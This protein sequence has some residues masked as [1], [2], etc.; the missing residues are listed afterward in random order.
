MKKIGMFLLLTAFSASS[1]A[2]DGFIHKRAR[3]KGGK[4][5][6]HILTTQK[7]WRDYEYGQG[8]DGHRCFGTLRKDRKGNL[9]AVIAD[10][11]RK[12]VARF[13]VSPSKT[14]N[15]HRMLSADKDEGIGFHTYDTYTIGQNGLRFKQAGDSYYQ[16]SIKK[17][18]KTATC[19]VDF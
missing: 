1:L 5:I 2:N 17:G 4:T 3:L 6:H 16:V 8:D 9:H 7:D 14:Y 12:V 18:N 10:E 13:Y 11:N 15:L 19:T